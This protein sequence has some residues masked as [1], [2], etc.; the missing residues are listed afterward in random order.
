MI[1]QHPFKAEHIDKIILQP[2]QEH[3]KEFLTPEVLKSL[4]TKDSYTFSADGR[5]I[6]CCGILRVWKGRAI[7]WCFL[8]EMSVKHKLALTRMVKYY[9]EYIDVDRLEI[10]VDVNFEGGHKWAKMLGFKCEAPLMRKFQVNGTD[11]ALYA[12]VRE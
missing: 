8:S 7:M 4:E 11:N 2:A 5:I 6:A 1:L 3:L 10:N 9:T 12:K